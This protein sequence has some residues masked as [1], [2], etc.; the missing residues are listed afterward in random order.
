MENN[1]IKKAFTL[2]ELILVV[3]II[4]LVYSLVLGKISNK[5]NIEVQSL[6]DLKNILIKNNIKE[7]IVYDKCKKTKPN[8]ITPEIFNNIKVYTVRNENIEK[9]EF[10][11][12]KIKDD[13]FDVC[14][15]F[16]INDNKSSSSYIIKQ[17]EKYYVFHPYFQKTKVFDSEDEAISDFINKKEKD[18][19]KNEN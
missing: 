16:E 3:I 14:L 18:E 2:F 11:P 5:K 7:L 15:K 17:N 10:N 13:I 1:L 8:S 19:F 6:K 9:I 12:I 4:G